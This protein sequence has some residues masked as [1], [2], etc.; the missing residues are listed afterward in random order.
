MSDCKPVT[1]NLEVGRFAGQSV[2]LSKLKAPGSGEVHTMQ[3]TEA[4]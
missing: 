4:P 1:V 2:R 3:E